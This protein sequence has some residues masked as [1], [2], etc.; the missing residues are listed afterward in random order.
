MSA[1]IKQFGRYALYE[2]LAV[3]GMATVHL[4]KLTGPD[5]F[6]RTVAIKRLHEQ[7]AAETE[8]VSM[9][10]D[11][12][13]LV[14]RIR[15]PN[16]VQ[17][18][19]V[20]RDGADVLLVMEYVHGESL[21][22]LMQVSKR[23]GPIPLPIISGIMIGALQGLHAAHEARSEDGELLNL[24][25]RDISPQNIM[26]GLDGIPRVLDFGIAKASGRIQTTDDGVLKGK[27]A[28]MAPE[29]FRSQPTDRRVDIW[30]AGVVLWELVAGRRLFEAEVQLAVL[31]KVLDDSIPRLEAAR[32]GGVASIQ[33]V[34]DRAL[35]RTVAD[36]FAT[37]DEM[38]AALEREVPPA[39][40][41]QIAEWASSLSTASLERRASAIRAMESRKMV[42]PLEAN[43]SGPVIEQA[44]QTT[45][46]ISNTDS[47]R[48]SSVGRSRRNFS[49]LFAGFALLSLAFAGFMYFRGNASSVRS[50]TRVSSDRVRFAPGM[51]SAT[52]AAPPPT[53]TPVE[54]EKPQAAPQRPAITNAAGQSRPRPAAPT[55][56][57]S[58]PPAAQ[59][60]PP[61]TLG[62][63]PDFIRKPKPECM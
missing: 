19:D 53:S 23:L 38:A 24:V 59:C 42:A 17:I 11:E 22:R 47:G 5:G 16:V 60:N 36:R 55:A 3:G 45:A 32:P 37:A 40:T 48:P 6:S 43:E 9:L 50:E 61:Y 52:P 4:G 41:R 49:P 34:L 62:P 12:A 35:T 21:S 51:M 54:P 1:P 7:F 31:P 2:P 8:F 63:A 14:T 33:S 29:Q 26:V 39:T 13:R 30:A 56:V 57:T 58:A 10:L 25:H 20:I 18:L 44:T 46:S 28:Y 27:L 15:H